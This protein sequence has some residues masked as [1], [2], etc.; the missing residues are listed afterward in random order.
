MISWM[1]KHRKYLVITIW[2]STIAFV[3]AGFVGWGAYQYGS[4][5]G[6]AAQVGDV[7]ITIKELQNRYSNL[8][9]YYNKILN[10]ELDQKKAKEIGLEQEAIS[11]LVTEALMINLAKDLG[12]TVLDEEIQKEIVSMKEFQKDGKFDKKIYLSVLK[13]AGLK[14]KDF[15]KNIKKQIL[16]QKLQNIIKP[17][18]VP[19]ESETAGA[20]LFM[21]DKIK[22]KVLSSDD[23]N[24][25]ISEKEVK[26]FWEKNKERYMTEPIFELSL[27]WVTPDTVTVS[28]D[29]IKKF[30][31]ENKSRFKGKD[32]KVLS[33]EKA[34]V[35]AEKELKLKLAKKEALKKYIAFKK[36]E[37]EPVEKLF[38]KMQN[39][40]IPGNIMAKIAQKNEKSYLK[41]KLIDEKY[42][43]IRLDKKVPSRPKSFEDAKAEASRDLLTEKKRAALIETA[44]KLYASFDGKETDFIARDDIDKLKP[45]NSYEA[46]EFLNELFASVKEQGYVMVGD[47]KAVVYQILGQKLLLPKKLEKNK[48]FIEENTLKL[49]DTLLNTNLV[50]YLRTK[51]PIEIYYKG[52]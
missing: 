28:E 16:L 24:V 33:F 49:K 4:A 12:L 32:G 26:E 2:I 36:G 27:I 7:K 30:Y 1:Q 23:I 13:S 14:P 20:A 40:I 31:E 46:A 48:N 43:I 44:K 38:L 29:K 10:G 15:E 6:K 51:Y 8:Y 37:I 3:G 47:N 39:N 25:S 18:L 35:L 41:P 22:Y 52:Q 21:G 9:N 19:L 34:K 45:L 5:S 42:A 11:S 50:N 17:V